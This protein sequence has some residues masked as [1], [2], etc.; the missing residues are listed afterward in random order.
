MPVRLAN[1]EVGVDHIKARFL[2]KLQIRFRFLFFIP[3]RVGTGDLMGLLPLSIKRGMAIASR[4]PFMP[5]SRRQVEG[6]DWG[7]RNQAFWNLVLPS[8]L[9]P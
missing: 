9:Q 6:Q 7:P 5:E 4:L 1:E 2:Q 3:Q 8:K